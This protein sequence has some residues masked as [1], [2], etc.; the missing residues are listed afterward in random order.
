MIATHANVSPSTV[1]RYSNR[2]SFIEKEKVQAIE[3]A[4]SEFGYGT[5]E[6]SYLPRLEQW[7]LVL[8]PSYDKSRN[9]YIFRNESSGTKTC[10]SN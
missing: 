3:N 2:S 1:S 7:L 4:M 5:K 9:Q 8:S 6:T 10:L